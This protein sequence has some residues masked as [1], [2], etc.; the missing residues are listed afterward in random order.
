MIMVSA[1]SGSFWERLLP[2]P[3]P[4]ERARAQGA[5]IPPEL[6]EYQ[7]QVQEALASLREPLERCVPW[8]VS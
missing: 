7:G 5:Q 3:W 2:W 4:R 6:Q 1:G 8:P